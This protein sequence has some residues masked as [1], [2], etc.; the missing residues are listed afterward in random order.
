MK[1][2]PFILHKIKM[3][4]YQKKI[5]IKM[6]I[7]LDKFTSTVMIFII[8]EESLFFFSFFLTSLYQMSRSS[9]NSN[10]H[11]FLSTTMDTLILSLLFLFNIIIVYI[12]RFCPIITFQIYIYLLNMK[13][14]LFYLSK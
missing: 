4:F 7:M 13:I 10:H 11:D 12:Y 6:H 8:S 5:I 14:I 3:H 1:N 9:K 2:I